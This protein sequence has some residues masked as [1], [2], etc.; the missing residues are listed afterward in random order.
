MGRGRMNGPELI[1]LSKGILNGRFDLRKVI[2]L[3]VNGY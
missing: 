1:S 2:E 3:V